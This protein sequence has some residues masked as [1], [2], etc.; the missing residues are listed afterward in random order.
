MCKKTVIFGLVLLL[1]GAGLLG[2]VFTERKKERHVQQEQQERFKAN[3]NKVNEAVGDEIDLRKF[4]DF[5]YDENYLQKSDKYKK[6]EETRG[7]ILSVSG[8]LTLT[9]GTI[10]S[11]GCY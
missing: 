8:V 9:G 11:C 3:L 4:G 1:A 7:L 10:L 2:W 6:Q 5:D